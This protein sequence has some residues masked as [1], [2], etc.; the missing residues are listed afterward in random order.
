MIGVF[1]SGIGGLTVLRE[2]IRE[3]PECGFLY[4]GDT[5]RTPYG[6]KSAETVRRYAR[7]DVQFLLDRGARFLVVACNTVSA[8]A[9]NELRVLFPHIP[10]IEVVTPAVEEACAATRNGRIGVIGTRATILSGVYE[11]EVR[12]RLPTLEIVGVA[13]PLL[14]PLVEEG[15]LDRD[16]TRAIVHEYLAPIRSADVDTLILG[17]T[18]FPLLETLI[19]AAVGAGVTIINPALAAARATR[20]QLGRDPSLA[21]ACRSATRQFLVTDRTPHFE[22]IAA[23]WLRM[24]VALERVE[25]ASFRHDERIV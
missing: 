20:N 15:W 3:L 25:L 22:R 5:A 14:V 16:I 23:E 17:C 8:V 6:T 4:L 24:P 9:A 1:D 10:I 18:H 11:R 19:S 13:C 7:E 2:L 12:R 21:V